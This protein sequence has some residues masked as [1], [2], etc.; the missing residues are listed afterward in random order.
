M[1]Y[2][3]GN[4]TAFYVD[5]KQIDNYTGLYFA[6]D[7]CYYRM[8]KDWKEENSEYPFI[9]SHGKTYNV[10]DESDWELTLKPRLHERLRMSKNMILILSDI[11]KQSR[12]LHEEI[13]YGIDICGLPVIAVYPDIDLVLYGNRLSEIVIDRMN[14]LPC[15]KSRIKD[16]PVV[17]IP[18]KKELIARFLTEP[19]FSV[20]A[21]TDNWNLAYNSIHDFGKY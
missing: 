16:V 6:A 5:E 1:T 18:F 21:K 12:A 10:R 13:T 3:N 8:L 19:S 20:S 14:N 9:D 17:H 7:Y 15:F 11:T 4:Y 2:R